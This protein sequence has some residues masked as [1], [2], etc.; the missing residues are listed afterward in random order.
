MRVRPNTRLP[1]LRLAGLTVVA[2]FLH[3][4]HLGVEDAEIYLPA[5]KKIV[6]PSLYPYATEFFLS[7]G[8]LSLF[9]PLLAGT[10]ILTHL[11]VDWTILAWYV[12]T[13]FGM[14]LSGWLVAVACSSR[15][16]LD[17]APW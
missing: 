13:L 6:Y 5:V 9:S 2:F 8:H 11:S 12:A 16:A 1:I 3:G 14:L 15:R 17:G 4:Y 7:H 10:A